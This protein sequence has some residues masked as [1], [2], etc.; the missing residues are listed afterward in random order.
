MRAVSDVDFEGVLRTARLA[1]LEPTDEQ[2]RGMAPQFAR[3][4]R[5]VRNLGGPAYLP[6]LDAH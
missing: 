6:W 1:G 3:I 4:L 2:A 5:G